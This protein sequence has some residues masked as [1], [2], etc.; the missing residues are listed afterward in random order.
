MALA[1]SVFAIA[2]TLL[3]LDFYVPRGLSS[4]G[5]DDALHE[6]IPNLGAYA[7]SVL[8]LGAFWREHRRIFGYVRQVD[9]QVIT[10][11]I[12]GLSV[13]ALL[14]FPTKLLSEYG[15][16][17]ESVAIYA[18]AVAALGAADL[19][20]LLVLVRRPWLRGAKQPP[21]GFGL[22]VLDLSVTVVV[23]VASIPLALVYGETAMWLWLVMAPVKVA[24]GRRAR[25]AR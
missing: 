5:Y 23:F 20:V 9:G 10:L 1:D 11:S 12:V 15:R 4:D 24:I 17:P 3:V 18:A 22:F 14:P 7:L 21:E 8:V 19:A 16:E 6:L 2:V 25:R 13:A